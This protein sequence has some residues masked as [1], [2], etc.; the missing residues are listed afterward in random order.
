MQVGLILWHD[1]LKVKSWWYRMVRK[2]KKKR[3]TFQVYYRIGLIFKSHSLTAIS[4]LQSGRKKTHFSAVF[5]LFLTYLWCW[6]FIHRFLIA[7]SYGHLA[8]FSGLDLNQLIHKGAREKDLMQEAHKLFEKDHK[9][10]ND[11]G[12]IWAWKY[13]KTFVPNLY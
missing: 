6:F 11:M 2:R 10:K 4:R 3:F 7:D 9:K 1:K 13:L 5:P 12:K 8:S